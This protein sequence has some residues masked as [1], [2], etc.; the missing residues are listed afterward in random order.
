MGE[1]FNESF[2]LPK[3]RQNIVK[4]NLIVLE[5]ILRGIVGI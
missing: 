2:K 3:V 4:G 5:T 1:L